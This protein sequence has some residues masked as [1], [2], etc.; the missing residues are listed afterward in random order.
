MTGNVE[1][2]L[3]TATELLDQFR[4]RDLSPLAAVEAALQRIGALNN[5]VNAFCLV[6][7]DTARSGARAS[8]RRWAR[9]EPEGLLDGVPVSIK[10]IFLTRG[11]PHAA[12]FNSRSRV[13][14]SRWALMGES[15]SHRHDAGRDNMSL[16]TAK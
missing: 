6:D 7:H 15:C 11:W 1:I 12:R 2:A 10:D 16:R 3:L 5:R 8:E 14:T 13:L 9:G 4:A